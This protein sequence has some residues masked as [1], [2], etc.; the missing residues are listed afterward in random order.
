M[1]TAKEK[2]I[3]RKHWNFYY[4]LRFMKD[5]SVEAQKSKGNA[6]GLLYTPE[7]AK[8]HLQAIKERS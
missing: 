7:Q 1:Y 3:I 8:Q 2:A 6:Y 4:K 5:G